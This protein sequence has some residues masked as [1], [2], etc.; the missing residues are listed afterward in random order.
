MSSRP[1]FSTSTGRFRRTVSD[2]ERVAAAL[3]NDHI[4]IPPDLAGRRGDAPGEGCNLPGRR[5]G[6]ARQGRTRQDTCRKRWSL[7]MLTAGLGPTMIARGGGS[8]INIS[9]VPS[10]RGPVGRVGYTATEG[11][12]DAMTRALAADWGPRG[13]RVNAVHLGIIRTA[14]LESRQEDLTALAQAKKKRGPSAGLV[15]LGMLLISSISWHPMPQV[16]LPANR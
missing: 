10:L 13:V 15:N 2:L 9:S 12:I 1:V 4:I 14:M 7:L 16:M 5:R 11:A 3:C 6:C 8:I